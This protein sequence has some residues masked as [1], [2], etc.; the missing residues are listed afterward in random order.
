[1]G[2]HYVHIASTRLSEKEDD[3]FLSWLKSNRK[4]KMDDLIKKFPKRTFI[5]I[6]IDED[7]NDNS[8]YYVRGGY[9]EE[10]KVLDTKSI[11]SHVDQYMQAI[12]NIDID[13]DDD[14]YGAFLNEILALRNDVAKENIR[15]N[16]MIDIT[17]L[18]KFE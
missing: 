2:L 7:T 18:L 12:A 9:S 3:E 17:D 14:L 6:N 10:K 1:M 4:K 11:Q 15:K 8:Y 16:N 5:V 13:G